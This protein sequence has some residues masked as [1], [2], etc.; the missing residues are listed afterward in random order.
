MKGEILKNN[1]TS[2]LQF[3]KLSVALI[4]V[5]VLTQVMLV[6]G[7]VNKKPVLVLQPPTLADKAELTANAASESY[8][9]AWGLYAGMLLGNVTPA[10]L[11]FIKTAIEPLLAPDI[12]H[13]VMKAIA[14]QATQIRNDRI[15]IS[16][17]P[18]AVSYMRSHDLVFVTGRLTNTGPSGQEDSYQWTYEMRI[19]VNNYMPEISHLKAYRGGPVTKRQEAN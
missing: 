17:E 2:L 5:L 13:S 18:T 8:K 14:D 11:E 3:K 15:S 4:A 12:Y 1:L 6:Y 10:R 19:G 9:K 7:L 16:Y